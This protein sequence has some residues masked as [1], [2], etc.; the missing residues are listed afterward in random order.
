MFFRIIRRVPAIGESPPTAR[1]GVQAIIAGFAWLAARRLPPQREQKQAVTNGGQ[2]TRGHR[3][4]MAAKQ[5]TVAAK[6]ATVAKKPK[7]LTEEDLLKRAR[8]ATT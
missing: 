5:A 3:V 1:R 6:Q 2:A 7:V 8:E 4:S